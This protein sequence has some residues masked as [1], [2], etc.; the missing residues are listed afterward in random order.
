MQERDVFA[1]VA[2]KTHLVRHDDEADAV[3]LQL[4]YHIQ[5]LSGEFGI[6]RAGGLVQQQ[7]AGAGRDGPR[8][9]DALLLAA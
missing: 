5:H 8:D 1:C 7:Q 9:G 4:A 2:R 6:Q 3:G